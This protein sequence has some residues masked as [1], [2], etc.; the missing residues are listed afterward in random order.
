MLTLA[1]LAD[2]RFSTVRHWHRA[3]VIFI[4]T[5]GVRYIFSRVPLALSEER[6]GL[7]GF[8]GRHRKKKNDRRGVQTAPDFPFSPSLLVPWSADLASLLSSCF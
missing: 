6:C 2:C 4:F 3:N 1:L 7:F 5:H 8:G